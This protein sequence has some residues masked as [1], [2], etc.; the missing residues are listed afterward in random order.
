ME[1]LNLISVFSV[2]QILFPHLGSPVNRVV[3][4]QIH[5]LSPWLNLRMPL[6]S[7][8]YRIRGMEEQNDLNVSSL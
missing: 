5:P 2:E 1:C 4:E 6:V 3:E 8:G 7:P